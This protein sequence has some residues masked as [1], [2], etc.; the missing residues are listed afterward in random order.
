VLE[1]NAKPQSRE[2][3]MIIIAYYLCVIAALR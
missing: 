2:D 1:I 3:A